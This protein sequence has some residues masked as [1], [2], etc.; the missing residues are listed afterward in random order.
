[1]TYYCKSQYL[2]CEMLQIKLLKELKHTNIVM[3]TDVIVGV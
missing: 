1:M 3:L 2:L